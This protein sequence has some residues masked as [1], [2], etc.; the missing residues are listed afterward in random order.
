MSTFRIVTFQWSSFIKNIVTCQHKFKGI[1]VISVGERRSV[2]P[3]FHVGW[4]VWLLFLKKAVQK[5]VF[6]SECALRSLAPVPSKVMCK[7]GCRLASDTPGGARLSRASW[8]KSR[9]AGIQMWD[10]ERFLAAWGCRGSCP[11][12]WLLLLEEESPTGACD[13]VPPL[14]LQSIFC[15]DGRPTS[16]QSKAAWGIYSFPFW[17]FLFFF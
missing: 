8:L 1:F 17:F 5:E 9:G 7:E 4:A 3:A 6:L 16:A 2:Y 15:S 14:A 12:R 10:P 13:G 11:H